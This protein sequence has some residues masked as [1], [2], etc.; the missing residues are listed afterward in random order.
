MRFTA[1]LGGLAIASAGNADWPVV[2]VRPI[3]LPPAYA[4]EYE[5]Y[6]SLTYTSRG[7]LY[8]G[9]CTY[10][11][12]AALLEYDVASGRMASL[13]VDS[14]STLATAGKHEPHAKLHMRPIEM[15]DGSILVGTH[16]AGETAGWGMT[17]PYSYPGAHLVRYVPGSRC[18]EDMGSIGLANDGLIELVR[19][20]AGRELYGLTWPGGR[21]AVYGVPDRKWRVHG[22]ITDGRNMG[23]SLV[24]AADG[25][26]YGSLYPNRVFAYDPIS[27]GLV[28]LRGRMPE[29]HLPGMTWHPELQ[30]NW[31]AALWDSAGN[32]VV[33]IHGGTGSWLAA[34]PDGRIV[35]LGRLDGTRMGRVQPELNVVQ[36]RGRFFHLASDSLWAYLFEFDPATGA[37]RNLGHLETE[38]GV[39]VLRCDA[40]VSDDGRYLYL[41]MRLHPSGRQQDRYY[42]PGLHVWSDDTGTRVIAPLYLGVLDLADLGFPGRPPK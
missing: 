18:L 11:K 32:R 30:A 28:T 21:L 1:V 2:R 10:E 5:V 13:S 36:A 8:C 27:R 24:A 39:D 7:R 6:G 25:I 33:A 22:R 38:A 37:A 35:V 40:A 34:Y 9:L 16:S 3:P 19:D 31:S 20:R 23:R 41:V 26:V 12:G 4:A 14:V 15:P 42:F 17:H 29:D